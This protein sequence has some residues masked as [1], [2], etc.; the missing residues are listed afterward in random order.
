MEKREIL[1]RSLA[2]VEESPFVFVSSLNRE[3]YPETRT[4]FNLQS[5]HHYPHVRLANLPHPSPLTL[6]FATNT[7]SRKVDQLLRD[8]KMSAYFTDSSTWRG[9]L[10]VG[11]GELISDPSIRKAL[12]SDSWKVYYREGVN[13][14]DYAVFRMESQTLELY[15]EMRVERLEAEEMKTL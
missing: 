10:L 7:S 2:L 15:G 9:L 11:R 3:G 12:W 8:P 13:D 6:Y 4:M 14:P 1:E 5:Q